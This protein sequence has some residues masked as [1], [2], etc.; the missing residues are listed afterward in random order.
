MANIDKDIL[1]NA[2]KAFIAQ[3]HQLDSA[4]NR[5]S[6]LQVNLE[7]TKKLN[8]NSSEKL[9]R[10][11]NELENI[12]T[13]IDENNCHYDDK[14]ISKDE[15]LGLTDEENSIAKNSVAE[16]ELLKPLEVIDTS[17]NWDDYVKNINFYIKNNNIT[18]TEDPLAQLFTNKTIY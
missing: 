4:A 3:K 11:E 16:L 6:K 7:K 15:L 8:K 5:V 1:N 10:L 18:I 14:A 13:L 9:L 17:S 12:E 2:D